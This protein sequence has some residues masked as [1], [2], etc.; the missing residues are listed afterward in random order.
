MIGDEGR[1]PGAG[2]GPPPAGDASAPPLTADTED[3]PLEPGDA[4][5]DVVGDWLD[6]TGAPRSH[7]VR[8]AELARCSC[9]SPHGRARRRGHERSAP[10][11]PLDPPILR[12]APSCASAG[13]GRRIVSYAFDHPWILLGS[14]IVVPLVIVG[15]LTLRM[16]DPIKRF[17]VLALRAALVLLVVLLLATPRLVRDDDRMTVVALIDVSESVARFATPLTTSTEPE[18]PM[19]A[20]LESWFEAAAGDRRTD[21]RAGVVVFDGRA[22]AVR[23]PDTR[24]GGADLDVRG[25]PGTNIADAINMGLALLPASGPRRLVL[26]SDGNQTTGDALAAAR[27]AAATTDDR[28]ATPIDILPLTYAIDRDV[29]VSRVEVPQTARPEQRVVARI[30]L[31]AT[32]ATRGRLTLTHEGRAV[33]LD[34]D[35]PGNDR[36]LV[37]PRGESVVL[38]PVTLGTF[39]CEPLRSSFRAR[40]ERRRTGQRPGGVVHDHDGGGAMARARYARRRNSERAEGDARRAMSARWTS[41]SPRCSPAGC[42]TCIDTTSSSSTTCR[43][44][45]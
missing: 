36:V 38:V 20:Q 22:L 28:S 24:P 39:T 6:E 30:V 9:R 34:P 21:D 17:V 11:P 35:A 2:S 13:H 33:D 18:A 8:D 23:I 3:V 43:R 7:D 4:E 42:S 10:L 19:L 41:C 16:I 15:W 31:D 14:A 44:G 12:T 32:E 25:E 5:G 1:D 27:R 37:A 26:M 40:R 45:A 29:Q